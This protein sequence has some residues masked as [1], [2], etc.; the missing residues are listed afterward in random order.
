MHANDS[1]WKFHRT[2]HLTKHPNPTL[3]MYG[4]ETQ[5]LFDIAGIPLLAYVTMKYAFGFPMSFYEWW[6]AQFFVTFTELF[7]H[8]GLRV[9]A[10][11]PNPLNPLLHLFEA[12]L[13][14]EDHD[15]HHRTGWKKSYNY[16]KQ[17]RAW[18]LLFGTTIPRIECAEHNVDWDRDIGMPLW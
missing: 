6:I 18:D 15:L 1:M 17:T 4:D 16:G 12:D 9:Y 10:T 5:E 7:G 11:T 13:I 3:S 2:H 8:S 14:I